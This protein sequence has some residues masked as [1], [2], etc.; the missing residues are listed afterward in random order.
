LAQTRQ[1]VL[2]PAPLTPVW[3]FPARTRRTAERWRRAV[4]PIAVV[5]DGGLAWLAFW[6]AH[7]ARYRFELGG[8]VPPFAHQRFAIFYGAAALF[9]VLTLLLL[10]ARGAYRLPRSTGYLDES[11]LVTGGITTAMAGVILL[12]FMLRFAPSRLVLVFAWVVAVVL[13]LGRRAL[14]RCGQRYLWRRGRL[15]D[16]VLVVGGGQGGRRLMQAMLGQ[17]ALGY[18]VVGYVDDAA[19]GEST[20]VATERRVV[21]APRLGT[22]AELGATIAAHAIDEVIIALP[23][24]DYAQTVGVVEQ[25]R[26]RGVPFKVVPDLLQLSLDRVD[27]DEVAGIPLLGVR[28]GAIRGSRFLLKRVIDVATAIVVLTLMALPMAAIALLIRHDSPGPVLLRQRRLGRDG[29][30]IA[31]TKFRTMVEGAETSWPG[32]VALGGGDPRLFKLRDDPRLTRVGRV[33]RRWSL[34]ELPQF[35]Q[36]LRGE[37]SVVGPRPPLPAEA[38]GYDE[39]HRQR[40]LVTPGITGLWQV[41]GRSNLGFDEMVRLDLYYAEHWSPWLDLKIIL[42]TVRAIF[43]GD[44]AY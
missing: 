41:N 37:M 39:W 22:T 33:L 3:R 13:L 31:M 2:P 10:I 18:R 5:V 19:N 24:G 38:A 30:E 9:T 14:T 40:L 8:D 17:P 23:A 11:A 29:R 42:R 4:A 36:V 32:L 1:D 6:L 34:D 26:L 12:A 25:C 44:G 7:L 21:R 27:L 28:D 35:A 15:V 43:S 16:R 20:A